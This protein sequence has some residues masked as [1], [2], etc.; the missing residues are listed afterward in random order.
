LIKFLSTY[1]GRIII[2]KNESIKIKKNEGDCHQ[3]KLSPNSFTGQEIFMIWI[4][5]YPVRISDVN[6]GC[7][8]LWYGLPPGR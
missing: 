4:L 3:L 2:I 1:A 5:K 7:P 8:N 6:Y